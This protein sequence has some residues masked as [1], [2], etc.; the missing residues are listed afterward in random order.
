MGFAHSDVFRLMNESKKG[1]ERLT[2]AAIPVW[3]QSC[4]L[5]RLDFYSEPM[6]AFPSDT[7][8]F[9]VGN[10][11]APHNFEHSNTGGF[12]RARLP[13][14]LSGGPRNP[15]TTVSPAHQFQ[16][17]YSPDQRMHQL[18]GSYQNS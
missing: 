16:R 4:A 7:K 18:Q 2:T 15:Q 12:P 1:K 10:Q 6:A 14:P 17:N 8:R 13:S 11:I 3:E 5:S 9:K